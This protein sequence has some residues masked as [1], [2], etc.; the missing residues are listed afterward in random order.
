MSG[1]FPAER[2]GNVE[3]VWIWWDMISEIC[4]CLFTHL[5]WVKHICASK[6]TIIGS[7]ND[8][9]PGRR[10]AIIW[11]YGGILLIGHLGTN[12]SETLIQIHENAFQ[13]I[14]RILAAICIGLNVSI[15]AIRFGWPGWHYSSGNIGSNIP[16]DMRQSFLK[17][18]LITNHK[19]FIL[20]IVSYLCWCKTC[21]SISSWMT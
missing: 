5:G 21:K 20:S 7:D 4:I 12:F 1:E 17:M 8:L 19:P 16:R 11:N 10:Q 2:V 13:N 6:L 18:N 14:V 9:S 3:Y 15:F